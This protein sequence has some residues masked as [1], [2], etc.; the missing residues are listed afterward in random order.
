MRVARGCW[1]K[2]YKNRSMHF[3]RILCVGAGLQNTKI[4]NK[5]GTGSYCILLEFRA[6]V[7]L[8]ARRNMCVSMLLL[9]KKYDAAFLVR[10]QSMEMHLKK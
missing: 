1:A 10:V 9:S 2:E 7:L 5:Y 8:S 3:S 4:S 6:W